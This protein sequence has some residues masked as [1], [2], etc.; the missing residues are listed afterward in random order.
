MKRGGI[1]SVAFK[2]GAPEPNFADMFGIFD[3]SV[4]NGRRV[5]NR[6]GWANIRKGCETAPHL[7]SLV[8]VPPQFF[9]LWQAKSPCLSF[10]VL[11][12]YNLPHEVKTKHI[13]HLFYLLAFSHPRHGDIIHHKR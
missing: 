5:R 1:D 4:R 2:K 6:R 7:C 3:T 9:Y 11:Y 13:P 8:L 10:V 12:H